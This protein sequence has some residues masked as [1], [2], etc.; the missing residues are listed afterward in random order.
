[1]KTKEILPTEGESESLDRL[2]VVWR[3][4]NALPEA[5]VEAMRREIL[6]S[7]QLPPSF[8][9]NEL[10]VAWWQDLFKPLAKSLTESLR[11]STDIQR[12]LPTNPPLPQ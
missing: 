2:L 5:R 1:M 9:L 8:G 4:Q 11:V 7:P 3:E 12:F 6:E 10:S